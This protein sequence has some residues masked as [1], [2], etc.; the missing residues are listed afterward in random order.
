MRANGPEYCQMSRRAA[1]VLL[2]EDTI[3]LA[4]IIMAV[5]EGMAL[6]ATHVTHGA[7]AIRVIREQ[8][9][10]LVL[11]DLG[12]P[13]MV[14]WKVLEA[15]KTEDGDYRPPVVVLTA[16]GDPANRLIGKLQEVRAYL[17]KPFT[18]D[19]VEQVISRALQRSHRERPS[20]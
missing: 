20:G 6:D 13:D 3:E 15:L 5:L 19:E 12:L 16:H 18:P 11:L 17:V 9:P 1:K 10:D 2:V 4:E 7:K 8:E 14:G